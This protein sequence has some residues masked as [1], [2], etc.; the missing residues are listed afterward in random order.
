MDQ[1]TDMIGSTSEQLIFLD[2]ITKIGVQLLVNVS[3]HDYLHVFF[4]CLT[5]GYV[6][7]IE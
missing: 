5:L 7:G 1:H 4:S 6:L 3:V 2:L